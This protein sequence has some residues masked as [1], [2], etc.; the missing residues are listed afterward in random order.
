MSQQ[1]PLRTPADAEECV[2]A[3]PDTLVCVLTDQQ[4]KY[5][6]CGYR[7]KGFLGSLLETD[8]DRDGQKATHRLRRT[9]SKGGNRKR[10]IREE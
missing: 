7:T 6:R 3:R 10:S 1:V 9:E 2:D 5:S 4:S 8:M